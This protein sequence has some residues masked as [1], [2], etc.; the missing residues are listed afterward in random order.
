[1]ARKKAVRITAKQRV[2]RKKNMAIARKSKKKAIRVVGPGPRPKQSKRKTNEKLKRL[3]KKKALYGKAYDIFKKKHEM[4][5]SKFLNDVAKATK[6]GKKWKGA[7]NL[8]PKLKKLFKEANKWSEKR[9]KSQQRYDSLAH[10][11]VWW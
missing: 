11:I 2:A 6:A 5:S 1:M 9:G 7:E 10:K 8:P 4:A 3:E